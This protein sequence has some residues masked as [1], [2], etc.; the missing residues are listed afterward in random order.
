MK[1]NINQLIAKI[2]NH[3]SSLEDIVCFSQWLSENEDNRY[4]FRRLNSYW[5][6]KT[7][8]LHNIKPKLSFDK[9]L[10][11]I[12][13]EKNVGKTKRKIIGGFSI[14][15]SFLLLTGACFILTNKTLY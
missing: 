7:S 13:A 6:G 14:A 3:E 1:S 4:E 9:T 12:N 2:L 10:M 15:A 11:K 5:N 8:F